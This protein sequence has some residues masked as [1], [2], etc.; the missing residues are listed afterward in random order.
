MNRSTKKLGLKKETIHNLS[1]GGV[2]GAA[3]ST[4]SDY[5]STSTGGSDYMSTSSNTG[6]GSW[7]R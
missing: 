6:G 4:S 1:S 7:G 3:G 5:M 2:G